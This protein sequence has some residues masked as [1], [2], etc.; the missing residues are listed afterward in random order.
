MKIHRILALLAAGIVAAGAGSPP[1]NL[2]N[3]CKGKHFIQS[4]GKCTECG[5][6]TTS[7][8]FKLCKGCSAKLGECQACRAS[9]AKP[10][11]EKKPDPA[12]PPTPPAPPKPEI[13]NK[14]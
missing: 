11:P 4:L 8:S 3:D 9:L 10:D 7:A 14:Q 6:R 1:V 2:C 13:K 12:P 5:G